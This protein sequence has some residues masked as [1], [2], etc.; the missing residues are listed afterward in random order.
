M[1]AGGATLLENRSIPFR[2]RPSAFV[3]PGIAFI[4]YLPSRLCIEKLRRELAMEDLV[5]EDG[6]IL[7]PARPGLGVEINRDAVSAHGRP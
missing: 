5:L 2:Y 1:P 6:E 4:E 3:T 7:S